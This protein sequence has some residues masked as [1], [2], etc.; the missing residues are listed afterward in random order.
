MFV[1]M[2]LVYLSVRYLITRQN[3][4]FF[5]RL[6]IGI[7][8]ACSLFSLWQFFGDILH[9]SPS[10]TFLGDD[11]VSGVFPFP[12]VQ[13]TFFEP[14]FFAN[15]LQIPL[16]LSLYQMT[17]KANWRLIISLFIIGLAFFLTLS[18]GGIIAYTVVLVFVGGF[19]FLYL[20]NLRKAFLNYLL[21]L[22]ISLLVALSIIFSFTGKDGIK[23]YFKQVINN[24]DMVDYTEAFSKTKV[25]RSYT[26]KVALETWSKHPL[27]IGNGAFGSLHEFDWVVKEQGNRRQTVNS[28]Y[29]EILVELGFIGLFL[30]LAFLGTTFWRYYSDFK[31]GRAISLFFAG[32]I[33]AMFIQYIAFS[34]LYLVYLW[35]FMGLASRDFGKNAR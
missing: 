20:R 13:S 33:L 7:G 19:L 10:L 22:L 15:F 4:D 6:F 24:T 2:F 23:T 14:L 27:G 25:T 21:V 9:L 32:I 5:Y 16:F 18:R 31:Q 28:L 11:Y 29:P 30:F 35:V 3:Q 26:I 34:T 12:R 17:R 1:F 8:L